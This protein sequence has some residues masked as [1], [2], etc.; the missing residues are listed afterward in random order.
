MTKAAN[1]TITGKRM[2][3]DEF[4]KLEGHYEYVNGEA[5]AMPPVS[6]EHNVVTAFILRA[7]AEYVEL[8]ELGEIRHDPFVMRTTSDS[9]GRA[10][11]VMFVAYEHADRIKPTHLEGPADLLVEVVSHGSRVRD[12]GDK[13]YEYEQGGVREYWI[14][15]PDRKR[16]EFYVLGADGVYEPVIV[17]S[18]G[19]Y[20]ST[21]VE[22]L[23]VRV[24]WFWRRPKMLDVLREW[25]LIR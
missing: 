13:Y 5:L 4:L 2:S 1:R 19:I 8:R 23:W 16:A 17:G 10:P 24:E 9:P 18:D 21:V 15:D 6:D 22:G 3:F 25:G 20:R 14:V 7:L 12:R 11:D